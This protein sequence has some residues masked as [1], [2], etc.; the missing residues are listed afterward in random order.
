VKW[1]APESIHLT[2]H[3]LGAVLEERVGGIEAAVA[4]AAAGARALFLEVKGA[5]GFPNARRPRVLWAGVVGDVQPLAALVVDLGR[6]LAPL[7][8]PAEDRPFSPHLTLGRARDSRGAAGLAG[9]LAKLS[10]Q[11]GVSWRAA[12][13]CLIR[14]VLSPAGAKYEILSRAPLGP[15]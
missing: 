5:G 1:V 8:F 2:L 7:G 15:R 4:E 14:S 13:I 3:F 10:A 6:R 9:G 12:D 11:E